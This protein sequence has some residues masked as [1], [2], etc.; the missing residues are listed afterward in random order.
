MRDAMT[1]H[2][3]KYGWELHEDACRVLTNTAY[4]ACPNMPTSV[5]QG[6]ISLVV[7]GLTRISSPQGAA[8]VVELKFAPERVDA[9]VAALEAFT[10]VFQNIEKVSDAGGVKALLLVLQ[11]HGASAQVCALACRALTNL[12]PHGE[13]GAYI[14]GASGM[15]LV[16]RVFAQHRRDLFLQTSAL[17]LLACLVADSPGLKADFCQRGGHDILWAALADKLGRENTRVAEAIILECSAEGRTGG[18]HDG[19]V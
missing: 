4:P 19:R 12:A 14:R 9:R 2:N 16:L 17:A 18:S 13:N 5:P 7:A 15:A 1:A 8:L 6:V 10:A 3:M 11:W